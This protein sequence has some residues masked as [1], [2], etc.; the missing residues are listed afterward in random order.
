MT[1]LASEVVEDLLE[2]AVLLLEFGLD[3]ADEGVETS[4]VGVQT[5]LELDG[6]Q[7]GRGYARRGCF[8][9]VVVLDSHRLGS[10]TG[11]LTAVGRAFGRRELVRGFVL[12][13]VLLVAVPWGLVGVIVEGQ[14]ITVECHVRRERRVESVE[15]VETDAQNER[16]DLKSWES[17]RW[18][19]R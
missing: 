19:E 9:D 11:W 17:R 5:P 15:S 13:G 18:D 1:P 12:P 8:N 10:L 6:G 4:L 14:M 16:M 7:G 3:F 2:L